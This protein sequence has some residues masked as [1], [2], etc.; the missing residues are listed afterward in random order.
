MLEP[1]TIF[2]AAVF[3]LAG[4]IKGV[5][6]L[7]LPTVSMGLL[8]AVM[9]T[10]EAATLLILPSAVT[11][12]WQMLAGPHL[13]LVTR[14][15]WP[16]M[17]GVCIGT[18]LGAGL[19][20]GAYAKYSSMALGATLVAYAISGLASVHVSISN[21]LHHSLGPLVGAITGVITAATGVFVVPAVPYL[22]ALGFE[23]EELV[24]ALGLSFTVSTLAL[25]LNLAS[26]GVPSTSLARTAIGALAMSLVGMWLGQAVRLRLSPRAFRLWFFWGLLV[27]GLYLAA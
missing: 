14:R 6:G 25:A 19:I 16:M 26:F 11:N 13:G 12:V 23:K 22:Q 15:L 5:I 20:A 7:G 27:L 18:W 24:Q 3:L 17:L 1:V 2:I 4:F 10:V 9:P 21:R 8:A